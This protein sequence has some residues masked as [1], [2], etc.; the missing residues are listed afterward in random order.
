MVKRVATDMV[1]VN[2]AFDV[3]EMAAEN[4]EGSTIILQFDSFIHETLLISS[5]VALPAR[6]VQ[7]QVEGLRQARSAAMAPITRDYQSFSSS[8]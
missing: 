4:V 3:C 6:N 8:P 1:M 2:I 5:K 7:V